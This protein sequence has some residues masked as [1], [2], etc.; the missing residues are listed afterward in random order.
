MSGLRSR[1]GDERRIDAEAAEWLI[2]HDR[3]LTSAEQDGFLQW[4]GSD[5]R[6]GERFG[7]HKKTWGRFDEL[8]HWRPGH[9]TE[10]NPDLLARPRPARA[11]R[12]IPWIAAA[13]LAAAACAVLAFLPFGSWRRAPAQP[14]GTAA[15]AE[16]YESRVL[17]DGSV[18][19]LNRGAAIDVQYHPEERRVRLLQG[20][21]QFTVAKS[22]RRP[23]IVCAANVAVRAVGTVFYV[24]LNKESVDVLVSEG[25]V[26]VGKDASAGPGARAPDR[27]PRAVPPPAAM[28]AA[29]ETA[30]FPLAPEAPAPPVVPVSQATITHLLGWRPKVLDFS[31]TPLSDVV[32][33]FNRYNR[34]RVVIAD[35]ALGSVPIIASFRSDNV[36]GFVRMLEVTAGV[37][38]EREGDTITLRRAK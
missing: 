37:R 24:R 22:A 3:G 25:H 29:G 2:R 1:T 18:V 35:P 38:A 9:S 32:A 8:V 23:F 21:A 11:R 6:H 34:E 14:P 30:T 17:D 12:A 5:P 4:L 16:S 33:E 20:E 7:R 13:A 27:S 31:S 15:V 28:L 36:D 19:E 10:P 26:Q